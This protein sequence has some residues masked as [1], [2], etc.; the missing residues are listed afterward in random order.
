MNRHGVRMPSMPPQPA[1]AHARAAD[2]P[3]GEGRPDS[4]IIAYERDAPV[5]NTLHRMPPKR[6]WMEA[7]GSRGAYRC[8]PLVVANQAGWVVRNP[9]TFQAIWD[10]GSGVENIRFAFLAGPVGWNGLEAHTVVTSHFGAGI[11]TFQIPF[12]FRTSPGYNLWVKGPAN[13]FKD[14]VQAL[15]GMVE[16]DWSHA[17]FTMN[18]KMTRPHHPI[19]FREGEASAR[20]WPYP[21]GLIEPLRPRDSP[22]L[23]GPGAS[24]TASNAGSPTAQFLTDLDDPD[25]ERLEGRLAEALLQP[26]LLRPES[27][28]PPDRPSRP[29]NSFAPKTVSVLFSA[30]KAETDTGLTS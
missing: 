9:F 17:P 15:E 24:P 27:L 25:S 23:H 10:G 11:F 3:V 14:G 13:A 29:V 19:L 12:L 1:L 18:W 22:P 8:L 26:R 21:R 4:R 5:E 7:T 2:R 28:R 6:A 30:N 16:T 20:S